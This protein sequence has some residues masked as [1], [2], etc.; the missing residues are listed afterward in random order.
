[1][2]DTLNICYF[3]YLKLGGAEISCVI[4]E[5]GDPAHR[6]FIF[7]ERKAVIHEA[8]FNFGSNHV[9]DFGQTSSAGIHH[10]PS[11]A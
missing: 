1:M 11:A 8:R 7:L 6:G 5:F 2:G 3:I 10:A 9:R 4:V